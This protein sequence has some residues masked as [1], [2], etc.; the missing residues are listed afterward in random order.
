LGGKGLHSII[1]KTT[2]ALRLLAGPFLFSSLGHPR[3][4]AAQW[5]AIYNIFERALI[6]VEFEFLRKYNH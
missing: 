5:V 2:W 6:V 4:V 3:P 1:D